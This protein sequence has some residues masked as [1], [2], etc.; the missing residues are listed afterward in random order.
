MDVLYPLAKQKNVSVSQLALAWLLHQP[1][2]SSVIIGATKLHQLQENLKSID[3]S[4]NADELKQLDDVSQLS[5]EY[6]AIVLDVM[7]ADRSL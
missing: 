7:T 5:K 1:A 6:P 2:V 3:V 4:F